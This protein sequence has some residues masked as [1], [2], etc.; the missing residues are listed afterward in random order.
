MA[1]GLTR[2][3]RGQ[4]LPVAAQPRGSGAMGWPRSWA[5]WTPRVGFVQGCHERRHAGLRRQGA[6]V[7]SGADEVAQ[8]LD[9]DVGA[10]QGGVLVWSRQVGRLDEDFEQFE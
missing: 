5:A 3:D 9:K 6:I 7:M 10:Q 1:T 4:L 2:P 8:A